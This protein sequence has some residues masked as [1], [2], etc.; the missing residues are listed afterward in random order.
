MVA[1]DDARV[2]RVD[3]F[4]FGSVYHGKWGSSGEHR[5]VLEVRVC[6]ES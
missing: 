5:E 4:G 1:A 2:E 6:F 3:S